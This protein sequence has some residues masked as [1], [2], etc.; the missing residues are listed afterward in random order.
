[1]LLY[2]CDNCKQYTMKTECPQ[3]NGYV[4]SAHPAKFSPVDPYSKYR[5]ATKKEFGLLPTSTKN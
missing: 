1:M 3:C 5:I 2:Y 4:R